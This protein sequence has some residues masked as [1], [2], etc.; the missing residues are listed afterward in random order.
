MKENIILKIVLNRTP[1]TLVYLKQIDP[2]TLD[3]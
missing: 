3:L 2:Y 1:S